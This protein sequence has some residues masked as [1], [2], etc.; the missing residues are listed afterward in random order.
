MKLV[1][2][3]KILAAMDKI[4]SR[5]EQ[6]SWSGLTHISQE[7]KLNRQTV[8]RYLKE[9]EGLG[10]V[11]KVEKTWRGETAYRYYMTKSGKKLLVSFKDMFE[12][13]DLTK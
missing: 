3:Q 6:F 9:L 7:A 5:G 1:K 10:H 4:V 13:M 12:G 2:V 8:W 11:Y